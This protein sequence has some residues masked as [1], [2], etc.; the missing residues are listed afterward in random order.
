MALRID[1]LA[2]ATPS[3]AL[4][5]SFGCPGNVLYASF[6][7]LVMD[8]HCEERAYLATPHLAIYGN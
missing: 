6:L 8:Q 3:P 5:L 1:S 7:P 2:P 4:S